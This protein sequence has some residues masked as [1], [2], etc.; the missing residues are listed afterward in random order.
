MMI[1]TVLAFVRAIA[2]AV[3]LRAHGRAMSATNGVLHGPRTAQ[4]HG[5]IAFALVICLV[6]LVHRFGRSFSFRD[7]VGV[8]SSLIAIIATAAFQPHVAAVCA[9]ISAGTGAF[10]ASLVLQ[11]NVAV[12]FG[13]VLAVP[14]ESAPSAQAVRLLQTCILALTAMVAVPAS[15]GVSKSQKRGTKRKPKKSILANTKFRRLVALLVSAVV[16]Y[17]VLPE[18]GK[19]VGRSF[20]PRTLPEGYTLLAHEKGAT[21]R[22]SVLEERERGVRFLISDHSILGGRYTQREYRKETIFAQFHVHE[23]V[24]LTQR[25]GDANGDN[26]EGGRNGRAL[27]LGLGIGVVAQALHDIGC[28]VHAVEIDAAVARFAWRYFGVR[29]PRV[30]VLDATKYLDRA[31]RDKTARFDYVVHDVFTGGAV[32]LPMFSIATLRAVRKVMLDDGVLALNFVGALDKPPTAATRAVSGVWARLAA[33]FK[34]VTAFAEEGESKVHNVVFFASD[35][36]ERMQFR[37]PVQE[38]FLGSVIRENTLSSFETRRIDRSSLPTV[39]GELV[40]DKEINAGQWLTA[41]EHWKA[42]RNILNDSVWYA[43]A[44]A[45]P[46]EQ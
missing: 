29:G 41:T 42:M 22:I 21:G 26:E 43:L 39:S 46:R 9:A 12:V 32:P 23:A 3:V 5:A 10:T 40:S 16:G 7:L 8:S 6:Q 20:Y 25:P 31:Q 24:R 2:G 18:A 19:S 45:E 34:H 30:D 38:D 17:A 1:D 27:C 4:L 13:A 15:N 14:M 28:D 11:L 35:V 37:R 36:P 33:V 44:A